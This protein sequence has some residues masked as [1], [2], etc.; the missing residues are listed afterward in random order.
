MVVNPRSRPAV[1]HF[2]AL[3]S[4]RAP[5]YISLYCAAHRAIPGDSGKYICSLIPL[6]IK[7]VIFRN[8]YAELPR[9]RPAPARGTYDF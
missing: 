6:N 5:R 4:A 7:V 3:F 2:G 1:V 9:G 8:F